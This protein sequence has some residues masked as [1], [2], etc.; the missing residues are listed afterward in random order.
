MEKDRERR[1]QSFSEL[2]A[3]LKSILRDSQTGSFDNAATKINIRPAATKDV[4]LYKSRKAALWLIAPLLILGLAAGV[5]WKYFHVQKSAV[6]N[7]QS[8]KLD[9]LTAHGLAKS[10]AISPDGKII[11]YA[12]SEEDGRQ[13]L[14]LAANRQRRR[15][16]NR[17]SRS[18]EIRLLEV[19]A[20]WKFSVLCR[21]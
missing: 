20:R 7:F 4:R 11:A 9:V 19:L 3:D 5:Y 1:Y 8:I 2:R 12:K 18:N 6:T 17:P 13:S 21:H 16:A 10:V 14:W 15:H